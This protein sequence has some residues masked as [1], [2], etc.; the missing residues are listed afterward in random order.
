[1]KKF[2]FLLPTAAMLLHCTVPKYATQYYRSDDFSLTDTRQKTV[3]VTVL[4]PGVVSGYE[5]GFAKVY[6][7]KDEFVEDLKPMVI[8]SFN[9][10]GLKAT[11]AEIGEVVREMFGESSGV[12]EE[13]EKVRDEA[14]RQI[15]REI[16]SRHQSDYLFLITHWGVSGDWKNHPGAMVMGPNGTMTSMGG[17]S[18]KM[19]YVQ[20]RG[21]VLD[22][23]GELQYFG[24]AQS[25][26][27]VIMFGFKSALK[28]SVSDAVIKF[29][30]L[31]TGRIPEQNIASQ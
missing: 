19:C 11:E 4:G 22:N 18:S 2:L 25:Q 31:L 23:Q 9:S 8:R 29:A 7:E 27:E 14:F 28:T 12:F 10:M 17:G 15:V 30:Q 16:C 24:E 13:G 20:L 21:A 1:M 26:S 5:K 6:G 3:V